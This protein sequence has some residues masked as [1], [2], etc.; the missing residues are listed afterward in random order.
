MLLLTAARA[1][2][3]EVPA[4]AGLDGAEVRAALVAALLSHCSPGDAALVRALTRAEIDHVSARRGGCG[5]VLLASCWLL[6]VLGD[7]ADSGLV[8]A[9]KSIDFDTH[10]YIDSA[11]LVTQG[12]E[13]TAAWA[14]AHDQEQLATHVEGPWTEDVDEAIADWRTSVFF[15]RVPPASAPAKELAAWIRQ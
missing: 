1:D 3:T 10:S 11:L 8:W 7:P 5:D 9:A 12:I 2:P 6:F 15:A 4:V 13:A 14:R